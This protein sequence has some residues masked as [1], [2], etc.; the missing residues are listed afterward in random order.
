MPPEA[1]ASDTYQL[2]V[3]GNPFGTTVIEI[4]QRTPTEFQIRF[5]SKNLQQSW[6]STF[7]KGFD[8][9]AAELHMP[10][11]KEP[12]HMALH[13]SAPAVSG[14]ETRGAQTE[15]VRAAIGGQVI[16]QRVDWA[17]MMATEFTGDGVSFNDYDP[18][19]SFSRLTGTKLPVKTMDSVLGRQR[20]IELHYTIQKK[21]RAE[22]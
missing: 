8:P 14:E 15:P 20:A 9:I 16:D 10:G 3:K 6:S 22:S 7:A 19:T 1:I 4:R 21:D 13:Y 5:E 17:A 18:G 11:R 2:S 12:Y